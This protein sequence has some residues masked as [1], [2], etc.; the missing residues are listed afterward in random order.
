MTVFLLS[1]QPIFPDPSLAEPDGLLAVGGDLRSE[2]LLTAYAQGIF[3]WY[4]EN[5]PI[6]WWTPDP[7]PLIE[8]HR[9][10]IGKRLR[11][12]LAARNFRLTIDTAFEQVIEH[13]ATAKRPQGDG[14]W[15]VDEMLEAYCDLHDHGFAHSV[16][17]WEDGELVGGLY[18]VS[19]GKAFFGESMFH[20]RPDASK[21]AFIGL[22]SLLASWDFHFV[23][24]QQTTPHMVRLGAVEVGRQEFRE[25][26]G[27]A[28]EFPTR[29]GMWDFPEDF[30]PIP[31][32]RAGSAGPPERNPD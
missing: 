26:L 22:C 3:P 23:D 25:R 29:R 19:L 27:H 15:I 11:R 4:S 24:C 5:T 16:E 32:R 10:H 28:V 14:T 12:T 18:G 9:V 20:R 21:A 7:R 8:P 2:R 1:E 13:C 30:E 31:P 17:A 6:L